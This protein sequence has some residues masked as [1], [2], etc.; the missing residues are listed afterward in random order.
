[1][2]VSLYRL[3]EPRNKIEVEGDQ[4]SPDLLNLHGTLPRSPYLQLPVNTVKWLVQ[5]SGQQISV[6]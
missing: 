1:M 4:G 2:Y 3:G 6:Y 5:P